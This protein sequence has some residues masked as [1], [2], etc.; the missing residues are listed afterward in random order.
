[1][2]RR[3]FLTGAGLA[4]GGAVMAAIPAP[5]IAQSKIEWKMVTSWPKGMAGLGSGA[6]RLSDRINNLSGGRLTVKLFS[7][8]ELVPATQCLDA[9][10]QGVADVAHDFAHYHLDKTPAAGLFA[11]VP[12][13]LTPDEFAGWISFGGG[14]ELWDELYGQFGVKPFLAGNTG[15]QMGGWLKKPINS[16]KDLVGLKFAISGYAASVLEKLGG[17]PVSL[18]IGEIFGNLQ[19]GTIDGADWIGPYN[20][21]SLGLYKVTKL[22]Y[23]PG[24]QEPGCG[25]E[26]L[27]NKR[28]YDALPDDLKQIVAAACTAESAVSQAEYSGRN[29]AA[30]ATLVNEYKVQVTQYPKP[31]LAAFGKAAGDVMQE[32]YDKSDDRTRKIAG[33]YFKFRK[34]AMAWTRISYAAFVAARDGK[35]DYPS[36]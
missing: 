2:K 12:F 20:D 36:G 6:E 11:S 18:P 4:A 7:A 5:A 3:R 21:L 10:S 14:Q 22:Y 26:A 25:V 27:V 28:K 24:F 17:K 9:V 29:P 19:N 30:L 33:S 15:V 8:G 13:G 31:V 1:M 32:L 34:Q 35:F 16:T 23:W